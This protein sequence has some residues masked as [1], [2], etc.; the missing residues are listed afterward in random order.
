M[1]G[2]PLAAQKSPVADYTQLGGL[3]KLMATPTP[4]NSPVANY[5]EVSKRGF[6]PT[7]TEMNAKLLLAKGM[8]RKLIFSNF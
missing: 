4:Y 7:N 6:H 1:L 2:S 3:K 8:N 5:T